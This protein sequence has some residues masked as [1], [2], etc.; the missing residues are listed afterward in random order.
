MARERILV[1]FG[2]N[3]EARYGFWKEG[4]YFHM[5]RF[6]RRGMLEPTASR[7]AGVLIP[8]DNYLL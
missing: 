5:G 8:I 1:F 3:L 4:F 7:R 2:E 6:W